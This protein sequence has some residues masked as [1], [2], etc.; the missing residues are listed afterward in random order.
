M[1]KSFTLSGKSLNDVLIGPDTYVLGLFIHT[2]Q[3]K[4]MKTVHYLVSMLCCIFSVV[5]FFIGNNDLWLL[6]SFTVMQFA[7]I[8]FLFALLEEH[9]EELAEM[10]NKVFNLLKS[11]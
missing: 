11:K 3:L 9:K 6:L 4:N 7:I 5:V 8:F 1:K 10:K 2:N